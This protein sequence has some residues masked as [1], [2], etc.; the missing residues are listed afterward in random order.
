MTSDLHKLEDA[1]AAHQ[2]G[3]VSD[4]RGFYRRLIALEPGHADALHLEGL[5]EHQIG[6]NDVAPR[7]IRAALALQPGSAL[8]AANLSAVLREAADSTLRRGRP[9]DAVILYRQ[10]LRASPG[11]AQARGNLAVALDRCGSPDAPAEYRRAL[12]IDPA[13]P[14]VLGN[15]AD[16]LYR[17][18]S[19]RIATLA[20]LRA[21]ALDPAIAAPYTTAGAS[22]FRDGRTEA[23]LRSYKQSVALEPA[24]PSALTGLAVVQ[25]DRGEMDPA[26]RT[27]TRARS[28]DPEDVST[29]SNLGTWHLL[30]GDLARGLPY[31]EW[32]WRRPDGPRHPDGPPIWRGDDLSGK[33][34]R[35]Y[36]E[37]GLGDAIQAVRFVP[38]LAARR[39]RVWL[40]TPDPLRRL[41]ER[42]PGV[43]RL[44]RP[45]EPA[46]GADR[47]IAAMSLS[48]ALHAELETL[49]STVPYLTVD[50]DLSAHWREQLGA[51]DRFRIGLVWQGNPAQFSEPGRSIP[52]AG[53]MPVLRLPG[54]HFYSMQ[55]GYGHEQLRD[56]PGDVPIVD[57]ASRLHDMADTAAALLN[58]DLAITTCTSVAHLAGA[59]GC[60]VWILLRHVPDWR[61]MLH[62]TDS[63]WYPTAR[64]FRQDRPGDWESAVAK[65]RAALVKLRA[66]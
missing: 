62:R 35:V 43:D 50:P 36:N 25:M 24:T 11:D 47:Q 28:I 61:W 60:P 53:L 64:L 5:A 8:F 55:K 29:N 1:V 34:I 20:A 27:L 13:A 66:G 32:R 3:R 21:A 59:L 6:A 58:L 40:D 9:A 10:A 23:S 30:H 22:A 56:L 65:L 54:C 44:L 16:R 63:A 7:S 42:I 31:Y 4:A 57:L 52:L 26:G 51:T 12:A 38:S 37:Q 15:F 45:D 46:A 48:L 39:A 14:E 49:G 2:A 18:T 17:S 19:W 41:F 33:T